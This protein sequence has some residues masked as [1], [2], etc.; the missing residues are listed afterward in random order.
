MSVARMTR[1]ERR[2]MPT[3][4]MNEFRIHEV[5]DDR[6][7]DHTVYA[8]REDAQRYLEEH[9]D[10]IQEMELSLEIRA[11]A[12][13]CLFHVTD[14]ETPP[15]YLGFGARFVATEGRGRVVAVPA[16]HATWMMMRL[17]SGGHLRNATLRPYASLEDAL[18]Q[19]RSVSYRGE[20]LR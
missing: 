7:V 15:A 17:A 20:D 13:P 19:A 9:R 18:A 14:L 2:R 5:G 8:S 12:V 1:A 16:D 11:T 4:T 6:P 3:T 10:A